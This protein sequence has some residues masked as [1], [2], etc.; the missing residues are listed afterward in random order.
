MRS[1]DSATTI[2][3]VS[4]AP[5]ASLLV[6]NTPAFACARSIS[7]PSS[8]AASVYLPA[9]QACFASSTF[10][11]KSAGNPPAVAGFDARDSNARPTTS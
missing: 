1:Y 6:A 9:T 5:R 4:T 2:S 11:A 3:A 10:F 8:F 7:G